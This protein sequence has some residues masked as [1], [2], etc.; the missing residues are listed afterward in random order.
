M[1]ARSG[2]RRMDAWSVTMVSAEQGLLWPEQGMFPREQGLL[3][4]VNLTKSLF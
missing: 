4:R 1:R 3:P 2:I